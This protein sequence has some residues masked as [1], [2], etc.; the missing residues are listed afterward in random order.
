[1]N[2]G[3]NNIICIINLTEPN[4][5][6]ASVHNQKAKQRLYFL[7]ARKSTVEQWSQTTISL[8]DNIHNSLVQK[9]L[10]QLEQSVRQN[11]Q[12]TN[13]LQYIF[14]KNFRSGWAKWSLWWN[15]LSIQCFFFF[16][17]L[18]S[19]QFYRS[20]SSKSCCVINSFFPTAIRALNLLYLLLMTSSELL[21]IVSHTD[22]SFIYCIY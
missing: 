9:S 11:I 2:E 7:R 20:F 3:I 14:P 8:L 21:F 5:L 13:F 18:P 12:D 16:V 6:N 4:T 22:V 19:G 1:M 15:P 17:S 10:T